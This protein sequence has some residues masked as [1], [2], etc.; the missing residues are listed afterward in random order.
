MR[1]EFPGEGKFLP[2]LGFFFFTDSH[3]S[4]TTPLM[5]LERFLLSLEVLLIHSRPLDDL[6]YRDLVVRRYQR[7]GLVNRRGGAKRFLLCPFFLNHTIKTSLQCEGG[8]L[9]DLAATWRS[10]V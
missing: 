5:L 10:L 8:R 3:L 1:F 4:I 2:L 7:W 9:S 6:D